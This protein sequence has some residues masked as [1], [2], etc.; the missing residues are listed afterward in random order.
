M[1]H[2][3]YQEI[4]LAYYI[5]KQK[6]F[7]KWVKIMTLIF[8]T[9]GIFSWAIWNSGV[10]ALI[11]LIAISLIQL[12]D[13][14]KNELTTSE[15]EMEALGDFRNK[16]VIYF[17]KLEKLWVEFENEE[18]QEQKVKN[19]FYE[20]RN[21]KEEIEALDNKLHLRNTKSLKNKTEIE[22]EEYLNQFHLTN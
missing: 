3:K 2:A 21:L 18:I 6:S 7:K 10:L 5:S 13:L 20:L 8:S 15:E 11:A 19:K 4:Y 17:N 12:V 22:T 1:V 14:I 9:S 16:H